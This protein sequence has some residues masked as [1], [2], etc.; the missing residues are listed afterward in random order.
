MCLSS[1]FAPGFVMQYL[2]CSSFRR[3]GERK[4]ERAGCFLICLPDVLKLLLFCGFSSLCRGLQCEIVVFPYHTD[5]YSLTL[6]SS[7]FTLTRFSC[8]FI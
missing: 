3:E 6:F 5:P 2:E 1:V 8:C 7:N 4:G